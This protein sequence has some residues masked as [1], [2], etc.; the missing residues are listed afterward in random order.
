MKIE[1]ENPPWVWKELSV[2]VYS[3]DEF[4]RSGLPQ[5]IA[6]LMQI[7]LEMELQAKGGMVVVH[8]GFDNGQLI[9]NATDTKWRIR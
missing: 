6:E 8:S 9:T 3:D 7:Q 2:L 5:S 1:I 4:L